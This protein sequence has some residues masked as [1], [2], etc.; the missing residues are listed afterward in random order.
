MLKHAIQHSET[1]QVKMVFPDSTNHYNTLFGGIALQ[2]MDEVAFITSTRF[3][4]QAF[5]TV[6][7]DKVDFKVAIPAGTIVEL[8]GIV[9]MVGNTSLQVKVEVWVEEMF[10][11]KRTKAIEG[12]FTM[13]C[14]DENKNSTPIRITK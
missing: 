8:I 10:E 13:V 5:V 6:S 9:T 11:E 3:S 12:K 2:W 4:R 7:S 14:V 1:R